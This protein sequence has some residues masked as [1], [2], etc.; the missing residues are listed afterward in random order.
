MATAAKVVP[1]KPDVE[2]SAFTMHGSRDQLYAAG[3][4]LRDKCPRASHAEWKAPRGRTDP[5]AVVFEAEKGRMP[6]LLPLRHGR[7]VRSAAED[8]FPKL[9]EQKGEMPRIKDQLPTIFHKD[10]PGEIHS[11]LLAG[12][13]NYRDTLPPSHQALLD[14]YERLGT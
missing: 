3:K 9:V 5:V 13:A 1:I 2:A 12:F 10:P 4:A 8:I 11:A 6:D 14:R 7:M